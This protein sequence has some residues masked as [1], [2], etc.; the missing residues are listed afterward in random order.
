[1]KNAGIRQVSTCAVRYSTNAV[2]PPVSPVMRMSS[3]IFTYLRSPYLPGQF[4]GSSVNSHSFGHV[5]QPMAGSRLHKSCPFGPFL[6][7][8]CST[9]PAA[10]PAVVPASLLIRGCSLFRTAFTFPARSN[11]LLDIVIRI[12]F[13]W[14]FGDAE[15]GHYKVLSCC[16]TLCTR[17][18]SLR[19]CIGQPSRMTTS[20]A[21]IALATRPSA[22]IAS[23]ASAGNI[24]HILLL[25]AG[26][27]ARLVS[28][29]MF[30][31]PAQ[32]KMI[33]FGSFCPHEQ[34]GVF[35]HS[36]HSVKHSF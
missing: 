8:A 35:C 36:F 15:F 1:M 31:C 22:P 33:R 3:Y 29:P 25:S 17:Q 13:R 6:S 28:C 24:S 14:S 26:I 16:N 2:R 10:A 9:A 19:T 5:L 11:D 27:A 4:S 30:A 32:G 12:G 20:S 23:S 18:S 34:V 7:L 21:F